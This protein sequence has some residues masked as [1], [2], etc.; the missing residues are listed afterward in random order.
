MY[1]IRRDQRIIDAIV[2]GAC[3]FW[4]TNVLADVPPSDSKPSLEVLKLMRREAESECIITDRKMM[5]AWQETAASARETAKTAD[6]AKAAV[7]AALGDT[8]AADTP[9]GRITY[10]EQNRAGYTVQPS[11]FRMLRL[12]K[13]KAE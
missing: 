12:K 5:E 13:R 7:I 6:A 8:E 1:V 3:R 9:L 10:F 4:D 2:D 11:S